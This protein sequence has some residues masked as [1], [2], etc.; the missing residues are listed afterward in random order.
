MKLDM[1]YFFIATI[2]WFTALLFI[3]DGRDVVIG[4]MNIVV[5]TLYFFVFL[6]ENVQ[7]FKE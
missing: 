7:Y 5:G 2:W 3:N 1:F 4:Y 6:K